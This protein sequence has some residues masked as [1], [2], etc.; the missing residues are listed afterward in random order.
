MSFAPCPLSSI[1]SVCVC[2][3]YWSISLICLQYW[4]IKFQNVFRSSHS[5]A[6]SKSSDRTALTDGIILENERLVGWKHSFSSDKKKKKKKKKK[7]QKQMND[8]IDTIIWIRWN[9]INKI[10]W[11][12]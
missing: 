6:I 9:K 3:L 5:L 11:D 7:N 4:L 10:E 8:L 1:P 2:N 12:V